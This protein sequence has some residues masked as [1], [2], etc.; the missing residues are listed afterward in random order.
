MSFSICR[1]AGRM[2]ISRCGRA[3]RL[4]QPPRLVERAPAGRE[5]RHRVR[6]NVRARQPHH[7]HR[8]RADDQRL[9][10]VEPARDAD[11]HALGAHRLQALHQAVHLDVVH[12]LAARVARRRIGRDVGEPLVAPLEREL[13]IGRQLGG[14]PH[15]AELRHL[16]G[17]APDRLAEAVLAHAVLRDPVE[18]DVRGDE[19]RAVGE[20]VRLGEQ[21]PVLVDEPVAV[22]GEIGGRFAEAGGA[23]EIRGEAARRL[24]RAE[25]APVAVLADD[26]VRRREVQQHGRARERRV[27]RR[28]DRRPQVLADL[29]V[30]GEERLVLELEHE[31]RAERDVLLA[32][33][34]DRGARRH[35]AGR[36]LPQ[37]VELA[38]VRQIGLRRHAEDAPAVHDHRAVEEQAVDDERH[39]DDRDHRDLA[40]GGDDPP[41]RGR[42][43]RR[44]APAGGT[45]PR[46]STRRGR[47]RGRARGSRAGARPLRATRP[48][49]SA[50][51]AGSATRTSGMQIATR[52]K[53]C[54]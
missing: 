14:E 53:L 51:N 54:R 40:R 27:R 50:L 8:P 17:M 10:R 22:P 46:R 29:G 11:H 12:L 15:G 5:A 21:R 13:A 25:L 18:I 45:G 52:A 44:A 36:E 37:L 19:L 4:H 20:A 28:R 34:I 32:E 43:C 24:V 31:A 9:R 48:T 33:E 2:S 41:E 26:D 3:H 47:A 42:A 30:E 16:V 1:H 6:E 7:V 23:V 38:V 49:C 35:V 39:A